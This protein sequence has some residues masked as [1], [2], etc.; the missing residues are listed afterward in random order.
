MKGNYWDGIINITTLTGICQV[1]TGQP[2]PP[3]LSFSNYYL[4]K[5]NLRGKVAIF[6]TS[7]MSFLSPNQQCLSTVSNSKH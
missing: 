2:V 7:K 3:L 4:M 5:D 1:N 6:F